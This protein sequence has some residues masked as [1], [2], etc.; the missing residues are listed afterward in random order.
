[1]STN[2]SWANRGKQ[3]IAATPARTF[4]PVGGGSNERILAFYRFTEP[5][6]PSPLARVLTQ[7]AVIE[8]T[9]EGSFKDQFEKMNHK[10]RTSE[11][12]VGLP[13]CGRLDKA[14][15]QIAQGALVQV[16]YNGK[17]E[18]TSGPGAGK[19]AHSF[20]VGVAE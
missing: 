10:V 2:T 1:M 4:K 9:Y 3:A 11:G 5:K 16:T 12:L 19:S 6:K 15:S 7:G 17:N 8:G 13:G 18:I 20:D 14:F